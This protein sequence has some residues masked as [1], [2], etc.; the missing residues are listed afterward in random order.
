VR[1]VATWIENTAS[2]APTLRHLDEPE[3]P[4]PLHVYPQEDLARGPEDLV[5]SS[6]D[7][8]EPSARVTGDDAR[9]GD[10]VGTADDVLGREEE[11]SDLVPLDRWLEDPDAT[12]TAATVTSD[13]DI[14]E[15][16]VGAPGEQGRGFETSASARADEGSLEDVGEPP[17]SASSD[18]RTTSAGESAPPGSEEPAETVAPAAAGDLDAEPPSAPEEGPRIDRAAVVRELAG[19][20]SESDSPAP[21]TPTAPQQPSSDPADRKRV[22]DDDQVTRGLIARLIDGV[23]GL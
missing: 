22:E 6:T 19:L 4:P 17:V 5:G 15:P 8:D 3:V 12:P 2:D 1:R 20:F 18:P 14:T 16:A 13:L 7:A 10:A 9:P 21:A 11:P 23:K